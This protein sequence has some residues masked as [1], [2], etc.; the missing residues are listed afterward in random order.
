MAEEIEKVPVAD[1]GRRGGQAGFYYKGSSEK[2]IW[3]LIVCLE[4]EG[5]GALHRGHFITP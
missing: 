2:M 3:P 4:R 1:E 5:V